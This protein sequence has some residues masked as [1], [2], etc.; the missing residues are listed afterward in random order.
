MIA[1]PIITAPSEPH[2]SGE[3]SNCT[4]WLAP[5]DFNTCK[6]VLDIAYLTFAEFYNMNPSVGPD[7]S[8]LSVGANYCMLTYPDGINPNDDWDED[9]NIP[10]ALCT[11]IIT[12]TPTQSGIISN[13]NKFHNVHADNGYLAIASSQHVDLSSLY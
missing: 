11:G 1:L 7:C 2:A 3:I 9:D 5:A 6:S 4:R 8:G 13:C 12:P 10:S